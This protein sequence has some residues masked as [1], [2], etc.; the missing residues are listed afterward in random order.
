MIR[1]GCVQ[2]DPVFGEID[3]NLTK[4]EKFAEEAQADILIFP[5]QLNFIKQ[6]VTQFPQQ[7]FVID[8]LAKPYIKDKEI[9]NWKKDIEQ[10]A[11]YRNVFCKISGYTTEADL[12]HWKKEDFIPYFD[13]V[14]NA[15]GTDRILFGSD[16]PV[17]LLGGDYN[18]VFT[19]AKEYF[20][21]FTKNEQDKIF[22]N[23]AI[24]FY[25]L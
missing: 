23:N 4:F 18:V 3:L 8:H 12:R 17:C 16:W 22:G 6:F 14:V 1:I 11:E 2:S 25:N 15:F 13:T 19:I 24:K 10:V 21:A 7:K 20:S 9:D 5:D